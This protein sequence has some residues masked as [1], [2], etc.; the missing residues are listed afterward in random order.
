[1]DRVLELGRAACPIACGA[2]EKR[3]R[4][5]LSYLSITY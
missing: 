4:A 5:M 1:M 2:K 3:R